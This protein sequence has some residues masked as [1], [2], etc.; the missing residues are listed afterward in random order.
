M[1]KLKKGATKVFGEA[2]KFASAAVGKTGELVDQAK[3]NYAINSN[4][5]K[6]ED[7]FAEV[8]KIVYDE[9]K[10]GDIYNAEITEKLKTVDMLAEE[11]DELKV[12]I[13]LLKKSVICP[14][15]GAYNANSN[16]FCSK[17]GAELSED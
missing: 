9:Y 17:C 2:E 8:G 14:D 5:G 6:I 15:C 10:N 12:K 3:L 7:I 1:D 13:A 11:I 4:E 16:E